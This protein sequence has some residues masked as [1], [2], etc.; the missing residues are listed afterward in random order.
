MDLRIC[1][2]FVLDWEIIEK[3]LYITIIITVNYYQNCPPLPALGRQGGGDTKCR[4]WI[5]SS[6]YLT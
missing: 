2:K 1:V 5:V 6:L 4:R 3:S